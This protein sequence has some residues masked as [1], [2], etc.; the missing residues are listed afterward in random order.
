M[1]RC[2]VVKFQVDVLVLEVYAHACAHSSGNAVGR[3]FEIKAE[4]FTGFGFFYVG[5]VHFEDQALHFLLVVFDERVE[6][7]FK[8]ADIALGFDGA[9]VD[10]EHFIALFVEFVGDLIG[11]ILEF[12][13]ALI[14]YLGE[15][16]FDF[17]DFM[18]LLILEMEEVLFEGVE[19]GLEVEDGVDAG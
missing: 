2:F 5:A 8:V 6:R 19:L 7:V 1:R 4:L 11:D 3:C 14:L 16:G 18:G 15:V 12:A 10:V 13:V 9:L 17:L